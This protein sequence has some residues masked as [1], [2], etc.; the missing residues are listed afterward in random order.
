MKTLQNGTKSTNIFCEISI[1]TLHSFD[2]VCWIAR[3][4][5][6]GAGNFFYS[7]QRD[8]KV[9]NKQK[10]DE[11]FEEKIT[12]HYSNVKYQKLIELNRLVLLICSTQYSLSDRIN[13][14]SLRVNW[15]IY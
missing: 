15:A 1:E 13:K 7:I 3:V 10:L 11:E 9:S 5:Q 6:C 12:H 8:S 2:A 14:G 4:E